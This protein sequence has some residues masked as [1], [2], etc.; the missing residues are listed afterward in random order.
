[1]L[2]PCFRRVD[3]VNYLCG[4]A[5]SHSASQEIPHLLWNP[6]V[7]YRV[8]KNPPLEP[9]LSHN[10]IPCSFKIYFNIILPSTPR[11]HKWC[12]PFRLPTSTLF[13]F[14]F[15]LVHAAWPTHLILLDLITVIIFGE[16]Y[17]LWSSKL[18]IFLH[19]IKSY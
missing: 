15:F 12:L 6:K 17:R 16:W 11:F 1:V 2:C 3:T 18:R 10:F 7:H 13:T 19:L 5:D 9:I 14:L 4:E 8:H